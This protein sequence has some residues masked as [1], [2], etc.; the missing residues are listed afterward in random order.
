[1]GKDEGLGGSERMVVDPDKI[2][3]E[4]YVPPPPSEGRTPIPL[5]QEP[6]PTKGES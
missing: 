6:P 5:P 4:G 1:M 3:R 2:I